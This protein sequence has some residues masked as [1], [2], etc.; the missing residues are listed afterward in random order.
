MGQVT[1]ELAALRQLYAALTS[2][3]MRLWESGNDVTQREIERLR[4]DMAYLETV[5]ARNKT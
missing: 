4:P 2:G 5:L 1:E 3:K